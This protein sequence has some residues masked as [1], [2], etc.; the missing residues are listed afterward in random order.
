MILRWAIILFFTLS[1]AAS[2]SKVERDRL[3]IWSVGQGS[4]GT[5]ISV[6]YCLHFDMGGEFFVRHSAL[7]LC[8]QKLNVLYISHLDSDHISLIKPASRLFRELCLVN[9]ASLLRISREIIEA[10]RMQKLSTGKSLNIFAQRKYQ[11]GLRKIDMIRGISDC[12]RAQ[13]PKRARNIMFR[14]SPGFLK[15]TNDASEIY[16]LDKRWLFSGDSPK[17]AEKIWAPLL[18]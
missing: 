1:L 10:E 2:T 4:W 3:Y 5:L 7:N 16:T 6:K 13:I 12:D 15:T 18:G 14:T 11:A 8:R 17:K 9:K